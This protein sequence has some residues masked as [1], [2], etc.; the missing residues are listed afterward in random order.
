MLKSNFQQFNW[1]IS[2]FSILRNMN[3][4]AVPWRTEVCVYTESF[5]LLNML[6]SPIK[7]SP[8][9]T[10]KFSEVC[11]FNIKHTIS[12]VDTASHHLDS[13]RSWRWC[14]LAPWHKRKAENQHSPIST[15]WGDS[16]LASGDIICHIPSIAKYWSRYFWKHCRKLKYHFKRHITL[17]SWD[18]IYLFIIIGLSFQILHSQCFYF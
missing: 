5:Q 9:H 11:V 8:F 4:W 14:F 7:M 10:Y 3:K 12:L 2:P 15:G 16:L 6:H 13:W 1:H 17:T 18:S